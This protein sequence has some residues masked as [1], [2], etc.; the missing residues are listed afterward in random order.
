MKKI[1]NLLV[2]LLIFASCSKEEVNLNEQI[3]SEEVFAKSNVINIEDEIKKIDFS[4][5]ASWDENQSK[6]ILMPVINETIK[7]LNSE[8]ISNQEIIDEF[9]SLDNPEILYLSMGIVEYEGSSSLQKA[10]AVDCLLRATG[11]DAFHQGFGI[12]FLTEEHF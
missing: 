2:V 11:L 8:G 9:G 5:V 1:S 6:T 3:I 4:N 10:D 7:L 12:L